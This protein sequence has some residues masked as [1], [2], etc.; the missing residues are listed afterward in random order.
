MSSNQTIQ[1]KKSTSTVAPESLLFG[2]FAESTVSNNTTLYI[3]NSS[4]VPLKIYDESHV[5]VPVFIYD[6]TFH[7]YVA[8]NGDNTN[9]GQQGR[10]YAT[11]QHGLDSCPA[12]GSVNVESGIYTENLTLSTQGQNISGTSA[13]QGISPTTRLDGTISITGTQSAI[14]NITLINASS[15]ITINSATGKNYNL[16]AINVSGSVTST[17][18]LTVTS[19]ASG[20]IN[21]ANCDFNNKTLLF[22]P[23]ANIVF[24]YIQNSRNFKI[25]AAANYVIVMDTNTSFIETSTNNNISVGYNNCSDIISATPANAGLYLLSANTTINGNALI[26]GSLIYFDGLN[27]RLIYLY[28]NAPS[29]VFLSVKNNLYVKTGSLTWSPVTSY[30][31]VSAGF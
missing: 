13:T 4:G 21:I 6:N 25:D 27:A 28:Y 2:E 16:N 14:S 7:K 15:T 5:D 24:V 3:G 11:I 22:S 10:P 29:S 26:K 30:P 17:N 18:I 12:L 1:I 8:K 20:F 19:C 31:I 23:M 9:N